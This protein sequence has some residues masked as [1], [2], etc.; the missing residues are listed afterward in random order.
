M[1]IV[2]Y[3]LIIDIDV[4]LKRDLAVLSL[5]RVLIYAFV[6]LMQAICGCQ[7]QKSDNPRFRCHCQA[8]TALV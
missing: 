5:S 4:S 2:S 1:S 7:S 8:T 3:M 6:K